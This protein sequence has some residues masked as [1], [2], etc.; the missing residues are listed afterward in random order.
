VITSPHNKR[1]AAAVRLKKRAMREKDRRF[2]VEGAQG[3]GEALASGADVQDL[4]VTPSSEER[5]DHVVHAARTASVPVHTVSPEVMGHLTSTVT[6]QGVVAV[7]KF[8]DVALDDLD[9]EAGC[10]AV[11]VEVRDPGNAGTILRSADASGAGGVVFTKSS[12][13]VYNPKAVRATAGSLFHVPVVRGGDVEESV[14]ALRERGFA[15]LAASADGDEPVYTRDLDA[16]TAV[17]FGNEA[18]GLAAEARALADASIRVPIAGRAESLNLAAAATL[19]LFESARQRS[20]RPLA[21]G[22]GR[23]ARIVAGAA[24]DIRSPLTALKGFA[25]TLVSKWDQLEDQQRLM[26]LEGLAHDAVRME[27]VVSQL[28]DAARLLSGGLELAP[29]PTDLLAAVRAVQQ[30]LGQWDRAEL[31]VVGDVAVAK[32][33]PVRL[34]SMLLA[35]VESAQWFAEQGPVEVEVRAGPPP[36]VSVARAQPTVGP[37]EAHRLFEP[38]EPGSG[39]GSKV[40][41]FVARGLAQ[42]HGGTL[43]VDASGRLRLTLTLPSSPPRPHPG[44]SRGGH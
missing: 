43:E 23:L 20:G 18:R 8:V 1:V 5:L 17:L 25:R 11:M 34:R 21:E 2:L 42:A 35:M 15:I 31:V 14:G 6:P 4:F 32:V 10:V 27:T 29:V 28:V 7:T 41:L 36:R 44:A 13:D 16:P 39:G 19:V 12:V 38:R 9:P 40:G 22:G 30:E 3:V 37:G 26:M 24:H 33:D